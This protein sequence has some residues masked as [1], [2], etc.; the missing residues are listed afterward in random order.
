MRPGAPRAAFGAW[1]RLA[2]MGALGAVL[3][4]AGCQRD[5]TVTASTAAPTASAPARATEAAPAPASPPV[6]AYVPK[7]G[8][9]HV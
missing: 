4:L 5:A 9:A 3:L 7:I 2:T 8:R 1:L 6:F